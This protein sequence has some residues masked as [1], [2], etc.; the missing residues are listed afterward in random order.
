M[1][2]SEEEERLYRKM[3]GAGKAWFRKIVQLDPG[4]YEEVAAALRERLD[5]IKAKKLALSAEQGLAQDGQQP[6][7]MRTSQPS[8]TEIKKCPAL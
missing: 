5:G 4:D 7:K 6:G 8:R 1:F 3:S 2:I